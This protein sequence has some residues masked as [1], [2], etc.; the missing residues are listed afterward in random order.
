MKFNPITQELFTKDN[1]FIKK[2]FCPYKMRW[3]NMKSI[4]N[5]TS[6][7]CS[8]CN[9]SIIDT[10]FLTDD[11]ILDLTKQN[12]QTCLKLDLNQNNLTIFTNGILERK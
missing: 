11:E 7:T 6:G 2:M 1:K 9:Q 10:Q 12:P 8:K 4:D 3:A 5:S